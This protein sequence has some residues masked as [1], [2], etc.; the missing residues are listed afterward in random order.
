M[1]FNMK[2]RYFLYSNNLKE[3]MDYEGFKEELLDPK[4][5][6]TRSFFNYATDMMRISINGSNGFVI[7]VGA[8]DNLKT[9]EISMSATNMFDGLVDSDKD[10]SN[11][12]LSIVNT[13]E[14]LSQDVVQIVLNTDSLNSLKR[15]KITDAL[16]KGLEGLKSQYELVK[17][18]A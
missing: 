13:I 2:T 18:N 10:I 4:I 17:T 8:V 16:E 3:S 1:G 6:N 11:L 12:I 14:N 5:N 7:E 9:Y 15:E